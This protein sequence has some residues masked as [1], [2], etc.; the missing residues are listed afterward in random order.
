MGNLE[1]ASSARRPRKHERVDPG[2]SS[3]RLGVAQASFD[4]DQF[5]HARFGGQNAKWPA[6]ERFRPDEHEA[7]PTRESR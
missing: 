1:F 5:S 7:N 4:V 3:E 2:H 6:F